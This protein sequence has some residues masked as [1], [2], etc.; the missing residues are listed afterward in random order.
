MIVNRTINTS[1]HVY[2]DQANGIDVK[3]EQR[4]PGINSLILFF[5][6]SSKSNWDPQDLHA[7][8]W[9]DHKQWSDSL[10][11]NHGHS[12]WDWYRFID[13]IN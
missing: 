8:S 4:F 12:E 3:L 5:I 7:H 13:I 6:C 2:I 1:I 10:I 9:E 11:Y